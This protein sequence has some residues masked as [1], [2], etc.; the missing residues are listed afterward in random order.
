MGMGATAR[1]AVDI[2]GTFTDVVL[3]TGERLETA[4]VLT[5]S[6]APE[7]AVLAGIDL[8]LAQANL[9][10]ADLEILIHGTTLATNA[11]I[12]RK[13]AVTALIT[14]EVFRD[15]L[16]IA[17]ETRFDQYDVFIDKTMPLIPRYLRLTAP[18]R[19]SVEGTVL[20]PLDED[21]VRALLPVLEK[22]GVESVA[23]G[24]LHAYA[25]DD[26][27]RRV[28]DIIVAAR[29]DLHVTLSSEVCP[30]VREYERLTTASANAYVQP[31][32]ASYLTRLK[33]ELDARG[34]VCP[35]FLMTSGG[36]LTTLDTAIRFPIRLVESGP[37]G[38][39]ILATGV[40]AECGATQALS[41][42]MGGTT[43]KIC[44]IE[45]Y[46]PETGRSS[47]VARAARF[48][49]GSGLPLRIPVVEMV[50]IGAGGGSIARIDGMGKIQIGPESAG[51]EPGP[52]CYNRGGTAPTITDGDVFLGRIDPG[53]FAGGKVKLAPAKS[54]AA[55][56]AVIGAP[57]GLSPHMA[58][59]GIIEMV[60]ENMAN[61]ARVHAIERGQVISE[62]TIIAFG[63][64]AP[65]HAARL[66]EKLGI[67]RVIVPTNAGV[68]SAVGFLRAPIS[69]EVVRSR[70][71]T[72]QD[73][74]PTQAN[75]LLADMRAEALDVVRAGAG[76]AEL[77]ETRLAYMRYRGQGHEITVALP[78][79]DLRHDDVAMLK[80]HY[81]Q[82]Y[83]ALFSRIIPG[84]EIE[85][86]T[87]AMT[88]STLS[89]LP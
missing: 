74:D 49:K 34:Y 54:G 67:D 4:K 45:D 35:I 30:E 55:I 83:A 40:A 32:M 16:D 33:T 60:D 6:G 42:D 22:E 69:Y 84:A 23:I 81:E 68:G 25:N 44:L 71:I 46:Q 73:F 12:E 38:G 64:A 43:A 14:T 20:R 10:P 87:W 48:K 79:R 57:L 18:E 47:E 85:I 88:V 62:H 80:E 63:G 65:L 61:A 31:L 86:L 8:V 78:N 28:R 26:H 11:I 21:A 77:Q 66:A 29:P 82:A 1:L 52:A 50:E 7:E 36:G 9:T 76:D 24:F 72:L 19:V 39:A 3:E 58:A 59:Y 75:A 41:F 5:T 2:G 15:I 53:S 13:G 51:S 56:E 89:G 70:Y 37:A 27:E 17:Y